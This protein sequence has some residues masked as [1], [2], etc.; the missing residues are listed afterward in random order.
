MDIYC[1]KCRK[2]TGTVDPEPGFS[3]NERY[4]IK[5]VCAECGKRKVQ[6]VSDDF[7]RELGVDVPVREP[8]VAEKKVNLGGA[9]RKNRKLR[10]LSAD[11]ARESPSASELLASALDERSK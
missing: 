4:C 6:F 8:K 10:K 9:T 11:A 2:K 7:V 1:L 3:K 5:G